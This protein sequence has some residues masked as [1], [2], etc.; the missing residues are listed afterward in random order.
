MV[1]CNMNIGLYSVSS[2]SRW[3]FQRLALTLRVCVFRLQGIV[4]SL[5]VCLFV[6]L[7]AFWYTCRHT[8]LIAESYRVCVALAGQQVYRPE[9]RDPK[10]KID[11]AR[12]HANLQK[13]VTKPW[14]P[15]DSGP[16]MFVVIMDH[17]EKLST[18]L[19]D[20]NKQIQ[21]L[22]S[23]TKVLFFIFLHS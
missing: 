3:Q 23:T 19:E 7:S 8:S 16:G 21:D 4:Q 13:E 1:A 11:R 17:M 20:A 14:A 9:Y 10:K 6:C 12:N 5:S 22:F 18:R 15:E 2:S